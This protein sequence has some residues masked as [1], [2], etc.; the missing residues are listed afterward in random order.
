MNRLDKLGN[1]IQHYGVR[2]QLRKLCEE[3]YELFEAVID[4]NESASTKTLNAVAE[5]IA[6]CKVVATQFLLILGAKNGYI[7][8][9]SEVKEK[10]RQNGIRYATLFLFDGFREFAEELLKGLATADMDFGWAT[11]KLCG[12]MSVIEMAIDE[13]HLKPDVIEGIMDKKIAR[14]MERIEQEIRFS[15]VREAVNI[16]FKGE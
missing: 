1:I 12:Y 7:E 10:R 11:E 3:T 13:Y 4:Y 8:R 2:N 14:Q 5:E 9:I 16:P 15:S 6:D